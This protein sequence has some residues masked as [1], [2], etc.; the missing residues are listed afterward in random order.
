VLRD[1]AYIERPN[2][3]TVLVV[4]DDSNLRRLLSVTLRL[5]GYSVYTAEN[6][7]I[8]LGLM[9]ASAPDVIIL[10]LMM[11]VMDGRE[12]HRRIRAEGYSTPVL[13]VSA[14]GAEQ[15]C[16]E[17]GAQDSL[18]KPFDPDELV[19]RVQVLVS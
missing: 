9:T 2:V 4:D 11:P 8:A 16:H 15:A 17:L 10:D 13:L 6:G 7:A 19:E 3:T 5:A 14:Y 18:P 1:V 12:F